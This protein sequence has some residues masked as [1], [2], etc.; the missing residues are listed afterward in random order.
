MAGGAGGDQGF[1]ELKPLCSS[2]LLIQHLALTSPHHVFVPRLPP[3]MDFLMLQ[4]WRDF[5]ALGRTRPGLGG[6][7]AYPHMCLKGWSMWVLW[8]GGSELAG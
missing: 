7:A 1:L 4:I 3:Q 8:G 5:C 6:P 2:H